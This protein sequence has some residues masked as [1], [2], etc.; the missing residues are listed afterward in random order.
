MVPFLALSVY[1]ASFLGTPELSPQ[2]R[3]VARAKCGPSCPRR[4]TDASAYL[5]SRIQRHVRMSGG[6]G[7]MGGRGD[8]LDSPWAPHRSWGMSWT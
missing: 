5:C 1:P 7:R 2:P 4:C 8:G 6:E 3:D